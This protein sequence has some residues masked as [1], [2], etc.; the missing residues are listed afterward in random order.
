[1]PGPTGTHWNGMLIGVLPIPQP[2]VLSGVPADTQ[3]QTV[4]TLQKKLAAIAA[5]ATQPANGLPMRLPMNTR[6][7][8]EISGMTVA[9]M[10]SVAGRGMVEWSV[11]SGQWS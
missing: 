3:D 4:A 8:N 11:V 6:T 2:E 9:R 7:V 10:S 5:V 1:M